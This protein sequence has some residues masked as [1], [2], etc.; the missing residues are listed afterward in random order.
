MSEAKGQKQ[1]DISTI[2]HTILDNK[3]NVHTNVE[4]IELLIH[5][6]YSTILPMAIQ[7]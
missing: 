2:S 6:Y 1:P 4:L 3:N 7:S 5:F